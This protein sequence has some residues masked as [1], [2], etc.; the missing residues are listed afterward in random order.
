MV[1]VGAAISLAGCATTGESAARE[2]WREAHTRVYEPAGSTDAPAAAPGE[3]STLEELLALAEMRNRG[4][5]AAH[6]RWRAA[7]EEVPQ[8]SA[9]P[10][11][12]VSYAYFI[13]PIE[14]RVGP[15]RQ[16]FGVAQRIPLFGK[17]GLRGEAAVHTANAA[18]A[19]V[20]TLR[21]E[22][23]YRVTK[24]WNDTYHLQ[25]AIAVTEENV[26]LVGNLENVALARYSAGEASH[27]AVIRAQVELGRLE[28]RLLS[29]RDRRTSL[30]AALNAEL[31]RPSAAPIAWPD[32]IDTRTVALSDEALRAALVDANPELSRIASMREKE[33]SAARLAGRSAIP[34]LTLGFEYIDTDEARFPNVADSGQDAAVAMASIEIPLW[35]GKYRAEKASA[36]ARRVAAES[37]YEQLRSRL[38]ADLEHVLYELRDAE[39]QVE[40]YAHT[41]LPRARQSLEVTQDAFTSGRNDFLDLIDAQRTLLEFELSYERARA[42]LATR[43]ARLEQ[44]VGVDLDAAT[45]IGGME[46]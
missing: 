16:R 39:R 42:D 29:L 32:S 24:L 14:T 40:L 5:R 27:A 31:D 10:D 37:E 17:L 3:I 38:L 1:V 41:L 19:R 46:R 44:I 33:A 35:F 9:L 7:L 15:Q 13:E 34:D 11:P 18:G 25:R 8:A 36:E 45:P 23:R 28:D 43:R 12:R 21:R 26:E 6:D 20:E 30:V 2:R 4:V 22:L